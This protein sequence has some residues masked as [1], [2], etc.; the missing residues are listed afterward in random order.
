[1]IWSAVTG[2][3]GNLIGIGGDFLKAKRERDLKKLELDISLA[4]AQAQ[5]KIELMRN[6]QNADIAWEQLSL[7]RS[8]WKDEFWTIV[9]SI[10]LVLCFIPGMATYVQQGFSALEA[11]TPEWYS[12]ALG[13]A[14][15]SAFGYRKI[16][17]AMALKKGAK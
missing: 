8:G 5:A 17:D 15:A 13:V 3:V 1:M 16:A 14:V 6:Q 10:P 9:L 11:S 7:E 2:L 12:W 4:T